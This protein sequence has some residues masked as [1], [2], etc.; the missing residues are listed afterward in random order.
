MDFVTTASFLR[1]AAGSL[2][3]FGSLLALAGPPVANA[4]AHLPPVHVRGTVYTFDNQEPIPSATV[5]VVEF[6]GLAATTGPDGSYDLTVPDGREITLYAKAAGHHALHT[7]TF[8]TRGGDLDHVNHQDPTIGIYHAL[9]ALMS[10]PLD[11]NDNPTQCVVV[12]TFSTVNVR[13]LSF[14]GFVD[15]GAHGVAGATAYA[16]PSL[17]PPVY[18]NES[19]IPDRTR[20][21]SSVDGGVIWTNVPT[22]TYRFHGQHPSTRFA[23]FR[24]DCEPGRV[25]NANPPQGLYELRPGEPVDTTVDATLAK[26]RVNHKGSKLRAKVK[27]AE[28]VSAVGDLFKGRKRIAHRAPGIYLPGAQLLNYRLGKKLAGRK[29]RLVATLTDPEG[30]TKVLRRKVRVRK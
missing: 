27:G 26:P 19:V 12:S 20:T 4:R 1:R 11:A 10:V 22:G 5:R 17:P 13:D 25:V 28:Y 23:S 7:Q 6:P 3:I 30:N 18:F 8:V 15:Y 21:E 2:A 14:Q 16:T 9:A 29:L 24:A